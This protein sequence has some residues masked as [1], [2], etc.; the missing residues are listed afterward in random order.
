MSKKPEEERKT[1]AE[2]EAGDDREVESGVFAEVDDVAGKAAEAQREFSAEVK[3]STDKDQEG[4]ENEEGAAEFAEGIHEES[5]E[6]MGYGSK[7]G[8]KKK[9]GRMYRA[10][11]GSELRTLLNEFEAGKEV[12]DFE[13]GSFRG[14]GAVGAIVADAGAKVVADGA[15]GGFLGVGGAHG[16][17]PSEDGTFGFEDQGKD[18]AGAHE[19]GELGEKGALAMDSVEAAGFFFGE[20]HGLYGDDFEAGFVNPCK[21]FTLLTATYGVGLDDCKSAFDCHERVPPKH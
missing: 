16:V 12:A 3:Q 4:A 7:E 21:D 2:E 13:G 11:T 9:K 14:V 10:P 8:R 17:A 6:K 20:A 1:E 18:L 19:V 15:G 5:V